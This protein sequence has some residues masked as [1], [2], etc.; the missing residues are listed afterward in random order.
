MKIKLL[1]LTIISILLLTA[2]EK[3]AITVEDERMNNLVHYNEEN[4]TP[5]PWNELPASL[6]NAPILNNR[7]QSIDDVNEV[8]DNNRSNCK[9][10]RGFIPSKGGNAGNDF[11]FLPQSN[12]DRIY[13]MVIKAGAIIDG[14]LLYYIREDGSIYAAGYAGGNGGTFHG[15]LFED[16]EYI[17]ALN[18]RTSQRVNQITIWTSHKTFSHGGYGG[19]YTSNYTNPGEQILGFYGKSGTYLNKLGGLIYTQE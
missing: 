18:L 7:T 1:I 19:S 12:C 6:Q 11:L 9:S 4:T 3:E 17:W 14:L 16:D 5:V 2:C 13:G 15:Y 8:L 10:Y